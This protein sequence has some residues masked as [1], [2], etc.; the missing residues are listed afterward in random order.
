MSCCGLSDQHGALRSRARRLCASWLLK[1]VVNPQRRVEEP[2]GASHTRAASPT[3][4]GFNP[5]TGN[6]ATGWYLNKISLSANW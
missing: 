3:V 2:D 4:S 1:F 6:Y 5:R